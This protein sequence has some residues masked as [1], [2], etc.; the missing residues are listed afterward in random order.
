MIDGKYVLKKGQKMK[1]EKQKNVKDSPKK[2]S[3]FDFFADNQTDPAYPAEV[4][5]TPSAYEI[6]GE[7]TQV[8]TYE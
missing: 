5:Q 2:V 8:H 1:Q 7:K 3:H 4:K 6:L